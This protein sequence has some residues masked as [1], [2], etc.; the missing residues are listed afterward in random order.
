MEPAVEHQYFSDAEEPDTRYEPAGT[1]VQNGSGKKNMEHQQ[2]TSGGAKKRYIAFVGNL[3]FNAEKA[4][5]EK[6]FKDLGT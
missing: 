1:K 4:D 6:L 5:L 2:K 3:P